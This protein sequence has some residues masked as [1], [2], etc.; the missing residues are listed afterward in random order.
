MSQPV[1]P[2][3]IRVSD[4]EREVVVRRLHTAHTDG[5]LDLAE[6]DARV[7]SAWNAKTRG[8]L[9]VLVADLPEDATRAMPV[10]PLVPPP[11]VPARKSGGQRALRAL[12][13]VWLS[14]SAFNFAIWLLVS[15]LGGEGFVHPW[16]LWV[17]VPWGSVLGVVWLATGKTR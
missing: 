4:A 9:L 16:F 14:V 8:D 5:S 12:T 3:D 1:R 10:V 17:A 6:F 11:P 7:V 2:E 15:L 13:T